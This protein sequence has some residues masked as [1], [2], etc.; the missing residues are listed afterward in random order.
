MPSSPLRVVAVAAALLALVACGDDGS[1]SGPSD[2]GRTLVGELGCASC[3]SID[4]SSRVG[5]T[6]KGLAGSQVRLSDGSTVTADRDYL[7]RAIADPTAQVVDGYGPV[8]PDLDLAPDEVAALVDY[9][10]GLG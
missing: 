3:H 10:E 8:M 7:T 6:W 5:P 4:G 2:R 9:I 1:A